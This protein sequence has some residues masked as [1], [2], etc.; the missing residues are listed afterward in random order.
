MRLTMIAQMADQHQGLAA[1][2]QGALL[3]EDHRNGKMYDV[4]PGDIL[5]VAESVIMI[6][7]RGAEPTGVILP[8]DAVTISQVS[9]RKT[10]D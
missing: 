9:N 3:V 7:W 6:A 8:L 5:D 2:W 1:E 4:G 10:G